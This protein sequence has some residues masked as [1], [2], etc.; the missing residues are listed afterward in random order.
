M[1]K[2][3]QTNYQRYSDRVLK[4]AKKRADGGDDKR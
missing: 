1:L 2:I 3:D 4:Q